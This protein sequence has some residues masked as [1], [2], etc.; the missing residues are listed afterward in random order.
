MDARDAETGYNMKKKLL[1][2][3][4]RTENHLEMSCGL[5]VGHTQN[6]LGKFNHGFAQWPYAP[7]KG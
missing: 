3:R 1:N 6:H 2:R 7:E 4:A 5:P